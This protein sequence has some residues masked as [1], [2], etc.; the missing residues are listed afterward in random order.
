[1]TSVPTRVRVTA[2][3]LLALVGPLAATTALGV[4]P[5]A[6]GAA[7]PVQTLRLPGLPG[8]DGPTLAYALN[9]AGTIAGAATTA[10]GALHAVTWVHGAVV[11]LDRGRPVRADVAR[12]INSRGQVV[13]EDRALGYFHTRAL[14]WQGG[15]RVVLPLPTPPP[16]DFLY[17]C[18]ALTVD[19][20]G[21]IGGYCDVDINSSVNSMPVLWRDGAATVP[22]T[23]GRVNAVGRAGHLAGRFEPGYDGEV[24]QAVVDTGAGRTVLA[25]LVAGTQQ[26]Q[27]FALSPRDVVAGQSAGQPVTWT[28]AQVAGL[29]TPSGAGAAYGINRWGTVVGVEG[30]P[31]RPVA[32]KQRTLTALGPLRGA[33][34]AVGDTGDVVGWATAA[35]GRTTAIRWHLGGP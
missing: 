25:P 10:D 19:D 2:A 28:R 21:L 11:D 15:R 6:A 31:S 22:W 32:W 3:V 20:S 13:G 14:L 16:G 18:F 24:L 23:W 34:V 9:G 29:P 30:T 5:A 33:A 8:A 26:D 27:A 1:M 12:G 17:G 4:R 7:V 35:S